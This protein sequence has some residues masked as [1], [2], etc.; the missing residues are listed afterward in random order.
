MKATFWTL[1]CA[2]ALA[3]VPYHF[4]YN[5]PTL[6]GRIF[7][8]IGALGIPML[9]L[10]W[11][12]S[13][14][15]DELLGRTVDPV[16]VAL[17]GLAGLAIWPIAWWAMGLLQENL[18]FNVVG[19]YQSPAIYQPNNLN[20]IW[21]MLVMMD[22]VLVPLALMILLWGVTRWQ[23]QNTPRVL[24][25]LIMAFYSGLFG[26]ALF[27]QGIVGFVG[28]GLCGLVAAIVSLQTRTA[29]A[30][31]ATHAT[32]MYA[33][34]GFLYNLLKQM[35]KRREDGTIESLQPY[36]SMQWLALVLIAGLVTIGIL[37]VIRFRHEHPAAKTQSLRLTADT[38]AALGG[39]FLVGIFIFTDEIIRRVGN[40]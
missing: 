37:Q 24:A 23:L 9:I 26:M 1:T 25:S 20:D 34:H 16:S 35:A 7:L 36:W 33:N 31:F 17:S 14:S 21:T 30:G 32:F 40:S 3:V 38:W 12:Y 13:W 18:L 4:L 10:Y 28:Y 22:V 8:V 5:E 15:W 2:A 6:G 29:W 19:A 27:G 39:A 11:Q